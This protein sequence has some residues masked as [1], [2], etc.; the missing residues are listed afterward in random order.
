MLNLSHGSYE[1]VEREL[2]GCVSFRARGG[3]NERQQTAGGV[4]MR[5]RDATRTTLQTLTLLFGVVFLLVG[6][7]G[8]IPGITSN[9][10]DIKFAGDESEAELLGVFQV[11]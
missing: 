7:L 3:L 9:F 1:L 10:D 6:V 5:D 11:S 2:R 4:G 8:F